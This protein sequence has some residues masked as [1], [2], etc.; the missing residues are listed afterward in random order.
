[1]SADVVWYKMIP[2]SICYR[3][4]SVPRFSQWE[5]PRATPNQFHRSLQERLAKLAYTGFNA[6]SPTQEARFNR[7]ELFARTDNFLFADHSPR[8]LFAHVVLQD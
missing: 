4:L 1:V 5:C 8:T 7:T 6:Q 3:P 2:D